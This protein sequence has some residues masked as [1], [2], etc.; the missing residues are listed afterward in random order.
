M[1]RTLLAALLAVAVA[2]PVAA[3]DDSSPDT[4]EGKKKLRLFGTL[5]VL[6][7]NNRTASLTGSDDEYDKFKTLLGINLSWSKFSA[8]AQLEYLYWSDQDL[9]IPGDLDRLRDGFELRK[10]WLDYTS[11]FFKG[12]LGTFFTS[13]S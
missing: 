3:Q 4:T 1:S 13:F 5:A 2:S 11:G 10:Y 9:V 7:E 8:G 12:R 6:Y